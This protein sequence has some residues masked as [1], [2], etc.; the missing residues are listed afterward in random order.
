MNGQGT[1]PNVYIDPATGRAFPVRTQPLSA[2]EQGLPYALAFPGTPATPT[3]P[4][5]RVLA[6]NDEIFQ[7]NAAD[8]ERREQQMRAEMSQAQEPFDLS[9]LRSDAG[10]SVNTRAEG[11]EARAEQMRGADRRLRESQRG[12]GTVYRVNPDGTRTA[13]EVDR[14]IFRT[15]VER[16]GITERRREEFAARRAEEERQFLDNQRR[17]GE[18]PTAPA[19]EG[20]EAAFVDDLTSDDPAGR[21]RALNQIANAEAESG[22][23]QAVPMAGDPA[24]EERTPRGDRAYRR[25]QARRARAAMREAGLPT[26]GVRAGRGTRRSRPPRDGGQSSQAPAAASAQRQSQTSRTAQDVYASR[27]QATNQRLSRAQRAQARL[28]AD[29]AEQQ[30]Q[31]EVSRFRRLALQRSAQ[32][33]ARGLRPLRAD[34]RR[35]SPEERAGFNN[36]AAAATERR[37]RPAVE[38][39]FVAPYRERALAGKPE[40]EQNRPFGVGDPLA[41]NRQLADQRNSFYSSIEERNRRR[42]RRRATPV[43]TTLAQN[44]QGE[45]TPNG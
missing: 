4:L 30:N 2:Q 24:L 17:M 6:E 12:D 35:M 10:S 3:T 36:A 44:T 8:I 19:L 18:D 11:R 14:T 41:V 13:M 20:E 9:G 39:T 43:T 31:D 7:R 5:A 29:R 23:G 28:Q 33:A 32:R 1:N 45:E 25:A 34:G 15:P 37:V 38:R 27:Q 22:E 21:Q 26:A 16:S 40:D 42:N